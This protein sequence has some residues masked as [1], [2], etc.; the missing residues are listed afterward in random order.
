MLQVRSTV[1][2]WL[3][4]ITMGSGDKIH[5]KCKGYYVLVGHDKDKSIEAQS[6][7]FKWL[8]T[9][10]ST[11]LSHFEQT[12]KCLPLWVTHLKISQG[13]PYW[14]MGVPTLAKNL[15]THPPPTPYF[16]R[17]NPIKTS[18]LVTFPYIFFN[19]ILFDSVHTG[20]ANFD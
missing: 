4:N 7:F 20:H 18:F 2:W 1:R 3:S 6:I 5:S 9:S 14:D 17:Y 12:A 19:F 13:F 16:S 11:I 15:L 10:L 8:L